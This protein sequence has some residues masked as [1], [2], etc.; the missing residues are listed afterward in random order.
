V[1]DI[2][3]WEKFVKREGIE[4]LCQGKNHVEKFRG[5]EKYSGQC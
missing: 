4:I 2:E 3:E 5:M 1:L